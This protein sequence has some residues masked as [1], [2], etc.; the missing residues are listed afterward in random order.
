MQ[1]RLVDCTLDLD[2]AYAVTFESLHVAAY[3][4]V[5]EGKRS[6]GGVEWKLES[7][8][9]LTDRAISRIYYHMNASHGV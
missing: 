5:W 8:S 9:L 7:K 4:Y 2:T 6:G 3:V 1:G